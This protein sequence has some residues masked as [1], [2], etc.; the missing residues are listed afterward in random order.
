MENPKSKINKNVF[1]TGFT[2]FFTDISSEMIYPILPFFLRSVLGATPALIGIIEGI[3]ESTAALSKTYFGKIADKINRY[4]EMAIIGYLFSAASKILLLFANAWGIVLGA[5]FLDRVGKGIRTSP[6]DIIISESVQKEKR[7][8]AFGIQRS[9]DFFGAF[10]GVLASYFI[11]KF[12]ISNQATVKLYKNIFMFSLIPAFIGVIFL[13][14]IIIPKT[15]KDLKKQENTAKT[16]ALNKKLKL[17]LLGTIIF[18]LGNSSNQFL[19]LRSQDIGFTLLNAILLY[20]IY[21]VTSS[22]F[23]PIF[24]SLSD[25]LGKKTVIITGYSLYAVVYLSFGIFSKIWLYP[26]IWFLYGIYSA[27]TEGVEKALVSD[28]SLKE[29]RGFSLGLF[30][31]IV[32]IGVLPASLI[33]GILYTFVG[34]YAPFLLGGILSILS[35]AVIAFI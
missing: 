13:F 33:A 26:I 17:F 1:L 8:M 16:K 6:R 30:S 9:M 23:S 3:A 24:G 4:K 10:L 18:A 11:I 25:K 7:G 29:N 2:S 15:L 21:N 19:L 28:L 27:M 14:F 34:A 35:I 32:G 31:T 5:R 20:L 22:I 12:F